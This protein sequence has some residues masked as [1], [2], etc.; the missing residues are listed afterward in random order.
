MPY[1]PVELVDLIID[2]VVAEGDRR[3]ISS[4]SL[5]SRSCARRIRPQIFH[6]VTFT[7][8]EGKYNTCSKFS[9]LAKVSPAAP[10]LVR[11]LVIQPGFLHSSEWLLK[12]PIL[13]QVL[14]SFTTLT[15]LSIFQIDIAKSTPL[16]MLRHVTSLKLNE[17]YFTA[18]S[19]IA[20]LSCFLEL[21]KLFIGNPRHSGPF[22]LAPKPIL[23][24]LTSLEVRRDYWTE[25]VDLLSLLLMTPSPSKL[26]AL[27]YPWFAL[28]S[29]APNFV[30]TDHWPALEEL[31]LPHARGLSELDK[32]PAIP[33]IHGW[34]IRKFTIQVY[35]HAFWTKPDERLTRATLAWIRDIFT[36]NPRECTLEDATIV[37]NVSNIM[38]VGQG[39]DD[40]WIEVAQT[41]AAMMT[42]TLRKVTLSFVGS[43][44]EWRGTK[45]YTPWDIED[46]IEWLR[47]LFA[48]CQKNGILKIDKEEKFP[49]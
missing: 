2:Q 41:L 32:L 8:P 18:E 31:T 11:K 36:P 44:A 26:K 14:P 24:N 38:R 47:Q 48:P 34:A 46:N 20:F 43:P 35:F 12:E 49:W 13:L 17:V 3:H 7:A 37:F 6:E 21:R 15:E 22:Q 42:R 10:A 16:T 28:Q 29:V 30:L 40:A 39:L 1:L 19:L 25:E 33:R 4:C 5:V 45:A 9:A 23:P 27:S